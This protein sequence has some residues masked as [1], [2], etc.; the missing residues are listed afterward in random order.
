[1]LTDTVRTVLQEQQRDA[2]VQLL[3]VSIFPI[4]FLTHSLC[5]IFIQA[6]LLPL[7]QGPVQ[8]LLLYL[9]LYTLLLLISICLFHLY[10]WLS[11]SPDIYLYTRISQSGDYTVG[12]PE[13]INQKVFN[14]LAIV[15]L[16]WFNLIII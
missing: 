2:C 4:H 7:S 13:E 9:I 3:H 8:S 11:S 10:P 14:D 6:T 16:T 12:V 15:S 1:M 5:V